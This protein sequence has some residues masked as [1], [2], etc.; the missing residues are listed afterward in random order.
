M[1]YPIGQTAVIVPVPHADPIVRSWRRKFDRSAPFG[2]PAHITVLY[3]FIPTNQ[4]TAADRSE[5]TEIFA[6]EK[7]F[8]MQLIELRQFPIVN[9]EPAPLYLAPEPDAP[10]QHASRR[11]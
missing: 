9:D 11:R 5:L 7:A 8:A 6:G 1:E 2:V 10:F 3:P 4:L